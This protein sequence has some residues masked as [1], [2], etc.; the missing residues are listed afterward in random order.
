MP[1]KTKTLSLADLPSEIS[2]VFS[3][4]QLSVAN[5]Q[6]NYVSLYKLH[7]EAALFT[8]ATNNERLKPIGERAFEDAFIHMVARVLSLKKGIAPADRVVKFIGGYTKFINEK[9]MP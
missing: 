3:Q 1:G 7:S 8:Q 5:H 4:A 2:N 6:K 9:G